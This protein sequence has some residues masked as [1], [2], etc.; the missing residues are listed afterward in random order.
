MRILA[1]SRTRYFVRNDPVQ[2]ESF[3]G[4]DGEVAHLVVEAPGQ[5]ISARRKR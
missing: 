2:L 1:E 3:R 5:K 4:D